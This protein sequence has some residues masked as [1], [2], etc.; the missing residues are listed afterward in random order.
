[1]GSTNVTPPTELVSSEEEEVLDGE[2]DENPPEDSLLPGDV[3]LL[4]QKVMQESEPNQPGESLIDSDINEEDRNDSDKATD[5][6]DA[7][8]WEFDANEKRSSDPA[9]E[10]CP[11]AHH[12]QLLSIITRHF[13]CHPFFLACNG[14]YQTSPQIREQCVQE[15]YTFCKRR[16]LSKVWAYFWM[17]WYTPCMWKLWAQLSNE[18]ILSRLRTTM[19]A[20]S[21]WRHLKHTYLGCM[22]VPH[23]IKIFM[24]HSCQR[25]FYCQHVTGRC[26][27]PSR[28]RAQR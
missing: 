3:R 26:Q 6:E 17:S 13:C 23:M 4:L 21:H 27:S 19:T 8:D 2:N 12:R 1:M 15:M 14:A 10:F 16:G 7:P 18:S 5:D 11:A 20:E 22:H 24:I 9:Y 28:D 25:H